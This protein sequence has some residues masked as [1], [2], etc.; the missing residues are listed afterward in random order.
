MRGL[1]IIGSG[2][3]L[4][5]ARNGYVNKNHKVNCVRVLLSSL[6]IL[7]CLCVIIVYVLSYFGSINTLHCSAFVLSFYYS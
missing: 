6:I 7:Y 5:G 3:R 4:R 2:L 1:V